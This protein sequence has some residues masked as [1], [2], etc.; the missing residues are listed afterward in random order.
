MIPA[1]RIDPETYDVEPMLVPPNGCDLRV[2]LR[3]A[4]GA[5]HLAVAAVMQSGDRLIVDPY[6]PCGNP[7][8]LFLGGGAPIP[9]VGVIVGPTVRRALTPPSLDAEDV[10]ERT[11]FLDPFDA[12]DWFSV[13]DR[14]M[15]IEPFRMA[16]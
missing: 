1:I 3:R 6:K 12:R 2:S 5:E 7:H 8:F 16:A 14:E 15:D 9:G 10:L 13:W 4:L 11:V